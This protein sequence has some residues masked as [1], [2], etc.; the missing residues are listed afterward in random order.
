VNACVNSG[1]YRPDAGIK[2]TLM[3]IQA[4]KLHNGILEKETT[5]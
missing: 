3:E 4:L 1:Y 5:V 2:K